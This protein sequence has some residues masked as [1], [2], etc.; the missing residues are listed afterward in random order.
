MSIAD[1]LQ[2]IAENEQRVYNSGYEKGKAEGGGNSAVLE[3]TITIFENTKSFSITGLPKAPKTLN[4][5]AYSAAA[6]LSD[7][8]KWIRGLD[9][10]AD[11]FYY[12]S[13]TNNKVFACLWL[14]VTANVSANGASNASLYERNVNNENLITFGNGTFTLKT[15][16]SS[17]YYF[18][19]NLTYRWIATF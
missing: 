12:G 18:G 19:E 16:E 9:Y 1:K 3:G 8:I 7:E 11:G 6:P 4:L 5:I 14:A 10:V 2:T 15:R 13:S 17:D